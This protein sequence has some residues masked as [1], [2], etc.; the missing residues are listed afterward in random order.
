M[1][2]IKVDKKSCIGCGVC[3]NICPKSFEIKNGK[4]HL[5]KSVVDKI[6]CEKKAEK[7]CPVRAISIIN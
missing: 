1:P 7:S 5:K 6:T 3:A 2:K 4:S